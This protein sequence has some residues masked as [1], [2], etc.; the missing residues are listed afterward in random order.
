MKFVDLCETLISTLGFNFGWRSGNKY[1]RSLYQYSFLQALEG[2][3][4]VQICI[5]TVDQDGVLM[6][7]I[8]LPHICADHL[9][10]NIKIYATKKD[11]PIMIK[12]N[13]RHMWKR[14]AATKNGLY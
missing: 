7:A 11:C 3:H 13:W 1:P 5:K 9:I 14:V 8:E 6:K 4:E 2:L 10:A 12:E